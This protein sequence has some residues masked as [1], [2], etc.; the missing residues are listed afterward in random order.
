MGFLGIPEDVKNKGCT[1]Q[2]NAKI[3]RVE[4]SKLMLRYWVEFSRGILKDVEN[5]RGFT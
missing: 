2:V 1:F 3:L 4:L 5:I